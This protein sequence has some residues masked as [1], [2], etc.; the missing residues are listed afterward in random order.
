MI[1]AKAHQ[2]YITMEYIFYNNDI[3]SI[4]YNKKNNTKVAYNVLIRL[5]KMTDLTAE[6]HVTSK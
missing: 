1:L 4:L 2:I 6:L 3:I 5:I